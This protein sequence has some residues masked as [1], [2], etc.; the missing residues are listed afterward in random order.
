MTF[1]Y[2]KNLVSIKDPLDRVLVRLDRQRPISK[3]GIQAPYYDRTFT[4]TGKVMLV[5][6]RIKNPRVKVGDTVMYRED[7]GVRVGD[8]YSLFRPDEDLLAILER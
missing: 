3:G 8:I 4:L 7:R 1:K 5:G 6:S 2:Q